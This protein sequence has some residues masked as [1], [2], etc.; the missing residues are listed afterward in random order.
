MGKRATVAALMSPEIVFIS[1][2]IAGV[3]FHRSLGNHT[4]TSVNMSDAATLGGVY[5]GGGAS[6]VELQGHV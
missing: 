1:D 2:C 4:W 5:D 6:P 3:A